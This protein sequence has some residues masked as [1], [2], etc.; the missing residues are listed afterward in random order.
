MESKK[1]IVLRFGKIRSIIYN[2]AQDR[3]IRSDE[4]DD[5]N[6]TYRK[7][8]ELV[9]SLFL[10]VEMMEKEFSKVK[11][12]KLEFTASKY[13]ME[14][15]LELC[16]MS[17]SGIDH[18]MSL[19]IGFLEVAM[20][21]RL[22]K[23]K[24]LE[25][26]FDFYWLD[27]LWSGINI[28]IDNDI[29]SFRQARFFKKLYHETSNTDLKKSTLTMMNGYAKDLFYLKSKLGKEVDEKELKNSITNHW[30]ELYRHITTD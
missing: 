8:N 16:G 4:L 28:Q 20:A 25:T 7:L 23:G 24:P 19:P 14:L 18:M 15:C 26:D 30:Y 2:M 5:F 6:Q 1:E 3:R 21:I 22:S 29:D 13:K 10:T 11:L 12:L 17:K 27:Q 9:E